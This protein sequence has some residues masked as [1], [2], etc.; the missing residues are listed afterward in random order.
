[1]IPQICVSRDEKPRRAIAA[2]Q[3]VLVAKFRLQ[4]LAGIVWSFRQTLNGDDVGISGLH[5]EHK[6]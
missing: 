6:T 3:G 5:S 4:S 2:L 1:M